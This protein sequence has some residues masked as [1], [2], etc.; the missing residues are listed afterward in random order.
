MI[1]AY[2]YLNP[3]MGMMQLYQE[4]DAHFFDLH[5]LDFIRKN[6]F[7]KLYRNQRKTKFWF[8]WAK[9]K[10]VIIG[11]VLFYCLHLG[12]LKF[13]I[14]FSSKMLFMQ[15]HGILLGQAT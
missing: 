13:A 14:I 12:D 10:T 15:F 4:F 2:D 8:I 11:H 9:A 6:Q 5:Y 3:I 7:E 1:V